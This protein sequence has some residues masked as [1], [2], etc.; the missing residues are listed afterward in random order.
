ME[1]HQ[2]LAETQ[3]VILRQLNQINSHSRHLFPQGLPANKEEGANARAQT[4]M[5]DPKVADERREEGYQQRT[6]SHQQM[7]RQAPGSSP[8]ATR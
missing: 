1:L 8:H 7:T 2:V 4:D 3:H 6:Q 5:A